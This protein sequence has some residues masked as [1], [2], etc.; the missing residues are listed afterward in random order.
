MPEK[1]YPVPDTW[2]K[3]ARIDAAAYD[4]LYARARQDP[5]GFW[6]EQAQRIDWIAPFSR[7]KH[8]ASTAITSRSNGSRTATINVAMNCLDR[9]LPTRADQTAI[10]WEGDD[11][12]LAA[13][14]P[15]RE[16]HEMSAVSPTCSRSMRRQEGRPRHHL[17]ADDPGGGLR[18]AGLRAHRRRPFRRL[19]R[20]FA[21][22]A[23]RRIEDCGFRCDH[24]R[25]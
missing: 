16:L 3:N 20:L 9:H 19:W 11:P 8:R 24:H 14:S 23:R 18:H 5:D 10:I 17:S 4:A 12:A 15:M 2:K 7:V 25:R 13:T 1:I 21:R 6:A 22:R